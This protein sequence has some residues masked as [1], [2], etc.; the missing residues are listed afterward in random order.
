MFDI[1]HIV[2]EWKHGKYIIQNDITLRHIDTDSSEISDTDMNFLSTYP[3]NLLH[4]KI[5]IP[6]GQ[7]TLRIFLIHIV[8]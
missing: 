5:Y 7:S 3:L 4:I 1:D 8:R 6:V 2:P